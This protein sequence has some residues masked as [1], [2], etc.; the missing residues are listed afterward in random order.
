MSLEKSP[1]K[2]FN[3][4]DLEEIYLGQFTNGLK[5][6]SGKLHK[7]N[8]EFYIGQ[9]SYDMYHGNGAYLKDSTAKLQKGVFIKDKFL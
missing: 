9:F 1:E 3:D 5:N 2:L 4:H 6:G 8:G 7:K